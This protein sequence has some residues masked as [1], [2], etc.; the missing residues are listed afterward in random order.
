MTIKTILETKLDMQEV[1]TEENKIIMPSH[2][3]IRG[4]EYY[5]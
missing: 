2:Q 4:K 1:D 5:K 3:N